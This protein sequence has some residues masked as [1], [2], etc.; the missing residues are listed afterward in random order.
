MKKEMKLRRSHKYIVAINV[1]YFNLNIYY[2]NTVFI[3]ISL[4]FNLFVL[5][6][7]YIVKYILI[8]THN[9]S[10][11]IGSTEWPIY[12]YRNIHRNS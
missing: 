3:I 4:I 9:I 2:Y 8:N 1:N 11:Y 6:V 5:L 12:S 10:M 7:A